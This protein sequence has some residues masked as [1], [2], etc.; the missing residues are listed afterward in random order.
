[1]KNMLLPDVYSNET[2]DR[3]DVVRLVTEWVMLS[4]FTQAP[5]HGTREV[6]FADPVQVPDIVKLNSLK[7]PPTS[8]RNIKKPAPLNLKADNFQQSNEVTGIFRK[9]ADETINPINGVS[10]QVNNVFCLSGPPKCGK[11]QLAARMCEWLSQMRCL[12]G[13]FS[14]DGSNET[15]SEDLNALTMTLVHQM[16]I[17]EPDSVS[18]FNKA[19]IWQDRILHLPLE[20]RFE[21]LFVE[22][23]RDFVAERSQGKFKVLDPLVFVIDGMGSTGGRD[24]DEA[25]TAKTFVDWIY[26]AGMGRLPRHVKFI[27]LMRSETRVARLLQQ[28]GLHGFEMVPIVRFVEDVA[29]SKGAVVNGM[30]NDNWA[31]NASMMSSPLRANSC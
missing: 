31:S 29:G 23:I 25:K 27:V 11:T 17:T 13:Y 4:S 14:F 20:Q 3:P 7:T 2:Y 16:S 6:A 28:K 30:M 10:G 9:S 21:A 1:M 15:P 24:E 18:S 26:S 12:G 22:P 19:L 5:S 8:P